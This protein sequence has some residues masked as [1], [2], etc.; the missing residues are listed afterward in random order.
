MAAAPTVGEDHH[1]TVGGPAGQVP[2]GQLSPI[3]R[4]DDLVVGADRAVAPPHPP[5]VVEGVVPRVGQAA[6]RDA[7]RRT[8]GHHPAE[9]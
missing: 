3:R 2:D 8:G 9:E 7:G 4:G 1:R 6:I 5:P